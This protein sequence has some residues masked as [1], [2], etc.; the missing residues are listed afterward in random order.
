MYGKK[1]I[2]GFSWV[3]Y[4]KQSMKMKATDPTVPDL[5][6]P[7]Y[8]VDPRKPHVSKGLQERGPA[9]SVPFL[10]S[11]PFGR[12]RCTGSSVKG[13]LT[14]S[15]AMSSLKTVLCQ[16]GFPILLCQPT[17]NVLGGFSAAVT[18][19]RS[20]EVGESWGVHT[21]WGFL[22]QNEYERTLNI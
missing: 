11:F 21:M 20:A 16:A 12:G 5:N 1:G 22:L 4:W 3:L 8:Y 13:Q 14:A 10:F 9:D 6:S 18:C 15:C 17:W 7:L 19:Y 2:E